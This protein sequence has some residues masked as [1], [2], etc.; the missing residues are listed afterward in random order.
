MDPRADVTGPEPAHRVEARTVRCEQA[1]FTSIRGPAG[2]GYR[3]VAASDGLGRDERQQIATRSPSHDALCDPRPDATALSFYSLDSGRLC[4]AHSCYAGLEGTGRGGWRTYTRA[5]VTDV[6]GF[7]RFGYNPFEM[8]RS[9]VDSGQ[10]EADLT[11]P[12]ALPALKLPARAAPPAA[13]LPPRV[14]RPNPD[15]P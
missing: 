10:A 9:L 6:P 13:A 1:I 15:W 5:V 14:A 3:L 11:P 4:L 2:S 8:A 12:P 7:A